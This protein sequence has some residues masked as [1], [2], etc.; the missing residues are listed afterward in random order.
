MSFATLSFASLSFASLPFA[1]LANCCHPILPTRLGALGTHRDAP[2]RGA[3]R[4]Y[5]R[6]R[7]HLSLFAGICFALGGCD[8]DPLNHLPGVDPWIDGNPGEFA[9]FVAQAD[10]G[11]VIMLNLLKFRDKARDSDDTGAES[12]ARYGELAAP[13]VTKHGGELIWAGAATQQLVGDTD[14]DWDTVLLVRWPSRQSLIDLGD[15]EGYQAIA[16]HR[17]NGLQRTMLIALDELNDQLG[18]S[19][20]R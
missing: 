4:S 18:A 16:H 9:G 3:A 15:D 11:P 1:R 8:A 6:R 17:T 20:S 5:R 7:L 19:S 12:Y 13:F 10:K 2:D 14:Y